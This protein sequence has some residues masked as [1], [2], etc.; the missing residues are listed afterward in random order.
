METYLKQKQEE[1]Q[2]PGLAVG[3]VKNG[4]VYFQ[5]GYGVATIHFPKQITEYSVFH[6]GSVSKLFTAQAILKLVEADKIGLDTQ[7]ASLNLGLRLKDRQI[8][9]ITIR[10]LLEH[11]S[12]LPDVW[13]Y[14]WR[15]QNTD[16]LALQRYFSKKKLKLAT[17]PGKE[18]RYSNLGYNLLALI[19]QQVEGLS[20][21][22]FV[23]REVLLPATMTTADFRYFAIPEEMR[24][25][26]HTKNLFGKVKVRKIYPYTREHAGSSTL[27]SSVEELSKWMI[28]FMNDPF[29]QQFLVPSP[30]YAYNS[31]GF[32][33][34][35][36]AGK[37]G[38]GHYG[39]DKG[40]RAFLMM[41]PSEKTGIVL[42]SNSDFNEDFR[43]DIGF[44]L[45]KSLLNP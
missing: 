24:L 25:S 14:H 21:E 36:V 19:V 39:G 29:H 37:D 28:Q 43:Q 9:E 2:L 17:S 34:Y 1:Y 31:L 27:N 20:F 5:Q 44:T 10:Q 18:Y 30:V 23:K 6:T 11:Q 41:V 33:L 4:Q 32:Q 15:R 12:G 8:S 22:T 3:I 40:F 45:M 35:R 42:L 7:L 38:F 26:P 16:S 13:G